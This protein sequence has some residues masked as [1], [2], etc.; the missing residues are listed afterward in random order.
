LTKAH[1]DA[2]QTAADRLEEAIRAADNATSVRNVEARKL[3]KKQEARAL[4]AMDR[5]QKSADDLM[6]MLRKVKS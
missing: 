4:K 5:W 1:A 6:K 2:A 3:F